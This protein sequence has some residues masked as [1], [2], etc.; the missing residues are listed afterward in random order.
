VSEYVRFTGDTEILQE[1]VHFIEGDLLGDDE[2]EL[3]QVPVE[4]LEQD[5]LYE[6]CRRAVEKGSTAG[7]KGLPLI[8]SGDW[9][10]GMN[11]VGVDGS[12]ESV[13]MAWFLCEVLER[14]AQ[15]SE[16]VGDDRMAAR[17]RKKAVE[18]AAAA[19][20]FAWDGNWYRR[21]WYD[22][23]TPIGTSEGEEAIIDS[24]SQSWAVISGAADPAR[25]SD[26]LDSAWEHLVLQD[27]M[28]ALLLSPPFDKG[29]KDPGYIKG[30]PPGVRENGGQYTH[31]A[32]WL[33]KAFAMSGDGERAVRLLT[34]LNP[35]AH[36]HDEK[37]VEIYQTEPYAVAADVYRLEGNVGHGG[38]TWYTGASSWMFRVWTEDVL[39][40]KVRGK[41]LTIDP[42]I[43][44]E[45]ERFDVIYDRGTAVYDIEVLNPGKVSRGVV[46]V[47]MD[48]RKLE[49]GVIPLSPDRP[50]KES[51][52]RHKVKV[53]MGEG[54]GGEGARG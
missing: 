34:W 24:I 2:M 42:T 11:R 10:D 30:Y 6:H 41:T 22:D 40:L 20:E 14:F 44:P 43:S 15:L 39:G 37:S 19:E 48:G 4:S 49:D 31:A 9:N 45:W 36:A 47:E 38:W 32:M 54:R 26:A 33:A 16:T 50:G 13:W 5:T 27:E 53:V 1:R 35:L 28:M 17:N 51:N 18:I 46:S 3:F 8:G 23:G 52:I 12:G 21:A 7:V 29:E 25:A